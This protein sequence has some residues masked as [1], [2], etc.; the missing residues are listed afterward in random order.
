VEQASLDKPEVVQWANRIGG[1]FVTTVIGLA[2]VILLAWIGLD[3]SVAVQRS[4]ALLIVACPCAL[5]LATPLAVS[6]ALGRAAKQKILV[7][8]G[9]V[10]QVLNRPGMIWLDKTGTLTLGNLQ[11]AQWFGDTRWQS[12]VAALESKSAHAV[13][14]AII[15]FVSRT[16]QQS[17]VTHDVDRFAQQSLG[18]ISGRV[19]GRPVLVGT[20]TL[21]HSQGIRIDRR[22]QDVA[23]KILRNELSPCWIAVDRRIV[24]IAAIGD[25]IRPDARAA[26]DKLKGLGWQV[27][28]MSGDHSW[29]VKQVALWLGIESESSLGNMT[30]EEKAK[31]VRKSMANYD[32]VVMV[33]DGVNDSVALAT[34]SVG[35]AV[36]NSA[37]A[38]L[39]AAPVY[40]AEA[41]L[42]PIVDLLSICNSTGHTIR[43]NFAA[44]LMYNIAGATLAMIGWINP[45][46]AAVLMPISSLTVVAIS[47]SAGKRS[48]RKS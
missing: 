37:E 12:A 47:L 21:L 24:A 14:A 31:L 41:G 44:S 23:D 11:V 13:G 15:D 29:I 25:C 9:D 3:A 1:Y 34:A 8:G 16:N 26:I 39:A 2:A 36:H 19:D 33:G 30:P 10:L 20:E 40:L 27:G 4:V 28:M 6:V 32:T 38:C 42:Q 22:W 7:K 45:L 48:V 35:I 46:V 43:L 17:S 5:A 18:G